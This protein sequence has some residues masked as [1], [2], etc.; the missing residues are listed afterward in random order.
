MLLVLLWDGQPYDIAR[1]EQLWE[2]PVSWVYDKELFEA[3]DDQMG[4]FNLNN[5]QFIALLRRST[6]QSRHDTILNIL[7]HKKKTDP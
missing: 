1:G 4:V 2:I 7:L 5:I 3:L 6:K